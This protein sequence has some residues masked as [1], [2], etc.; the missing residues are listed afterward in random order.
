MNSK[1]FTIAILIITLIGTFVTS[2]WTIP[3]AIGIASFFYTG[4]PALASTLALSVTSA[5]WLIVAGS[6][7]ISSPL[8]ASKLTGDIIGGLSPQYIYILTGI[9]IGLVSSLAA[10]LGRRLAEYRK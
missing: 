6:Q 1:Q 2:W 5:V 10:L 9:T 3:A 7:E 8:K 4:K